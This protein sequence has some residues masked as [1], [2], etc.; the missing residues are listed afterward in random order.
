MFY[1]YEKA[2][3][4][5]RALTYGLQLCRILLTKKLYGVFVDNIQ[6]CMMCCLVSSEYESVKTLLCEA[7][8]AIQSRWAIS[9]LFRGPTDISTKSDTYHYLLSLKAKVEVKLV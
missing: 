9:S 4:L 2:G 8:D 7:I 3:V 1:H 5:D 6:H